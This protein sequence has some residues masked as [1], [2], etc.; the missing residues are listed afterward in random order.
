MKFINYLSTIAGIEIY[1]LISLIIFFLF[2][3][4]LFVYVFTTKKEHIAE[5]EVIPLSDSIN[6]DNELKS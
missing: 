2:F 3:V 5:V 4:A 6:N 1:P